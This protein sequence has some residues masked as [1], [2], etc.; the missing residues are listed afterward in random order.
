MIF[1]AGFSTAAQVTEFSGRGVG[2]SMVKETIEQQ[3]GKIRIRSEKGKGSRF[4]L[5]IPIPKSVL[6]TN[7][8]FVTSGDMTF[9][10]PQEFVIRVLDQRALGNHGVEDLDSSRFIR[11]EGNLVPVISLANT[12]NVRKAED[13]TLLVV[14][15]SQGQVFAL[16]VGQVHDTEDAVIKPLTVNSLKALGVYQG[17]TFLGDGTVGLI[18]DVPGLA[19]KL[20]LKKM[21]TKKKVEETHLSQNMENVISFAIDYPGCFAIKEQDVFRVE[22]LPKSGIVRSGNA[23][24]MPY[25]ESMMTLIHLEGVVFDKHST[26]LDGELIATLIVQHESQYLGLMVK[27]IRDLEKVEMNVIPT[28]KKRKG[29]QGN[30]LHKDSTFVLLN[31]DEVKALLFE[32]EESSER[33]IS[34]AA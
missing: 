30:I 27:E 26:D 33:S 23:W 29:I 6:I 13:E 18:M 4:I 12:L 10:I 16:E 32:K 7:C 34:L 19:Q 20:S 17:G 9:G 22:V 24:V 3:H 31:L 14:L 2:M 1:E 28:L 15:D 5:D 11:F 8:L 25:R 21:A